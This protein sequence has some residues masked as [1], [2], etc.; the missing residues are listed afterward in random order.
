LKKSIS[1]SKNHAD[2][3]R[4]ILEEEE[5]QPGLKRSFNHDS[6]SWKIHLSNFFLE[7]G[8][9]SPTFV[10]VSWL[11]EAQQDAQ[12]VHFSSRP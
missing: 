2:K 8:Q 1:F 3:N 11:S 7:V 4:F 9:K 6:F 5:G 12:K 10:L